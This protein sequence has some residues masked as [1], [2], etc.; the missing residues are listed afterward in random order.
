MRL[1]GLMIALAFLMPMAGDVYAATLK[2]DPAWQLLAIAPEQGLAGEAVVLTP[3][4]HHLLVRYDETLPARVNG[5]NDETLDSQPQLITLSVGEQDL[6]LTTPTLGSDAQKRQ[7]AKQ[8]AARLLDGKGNE[9]AMTQREVAI[10]GLQLG[11][12]Y[13]QLLAS[14]LMTSGST[15]SVAVAAAP[16]TTGSVVAPASAPATSA[17]GG[18]PLDGQLQQLFLQATPEQRKRFISWAVQQF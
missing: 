7:Y 5:D 17:I 13:Q 3:G 10:N 4:E 18:A 15:S 6:L 11:V 1:R 12:N 14:Q 2:L 9:I 8:P 16:V